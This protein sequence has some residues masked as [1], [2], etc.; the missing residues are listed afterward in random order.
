MDAKTA[1]LDQL[2][3]ICKQA[4]VA[5]GFDEKF[6]AVRPSDR[7]DLADFQCNGL[8]GV[9]K[10]NKMNPKVAGEQVMGLIDTQD[11]FAVTLVNPGF[12]NFRVTEKALI[13]QA[14]HLSSDPR[15]LASEAEAAKTYLLDY[16]GPNLAKEMHV[17]HL[18]SSIV[19]QALKTLLDFAGHRTISD[20]HLGD[21]GL[22]IGQLISQIEDER[23]GLLAGEDD[24]DLTMADLQT[25]YP[26][27][28]ARS[29]EDEVFLDR[30]RK[31]TAALQAGDPAYMALW[32]R[33]FDAS[34]RS[35]Q[36]DFGRMGVGFDC[37]YGE[38]RYQA[39]LDGLVERLMGE[40]HAI[41]DEGAVIIPLGDEAL[42]PLMLRNSKGGYGYGA[43]DLATI[44]DRVTEDNPDYILYIVDARQKLHFR[45]VF[46][47]A[48]LCALTGHA[49]PEHIPFGTVNG[50]DGKPFKT[51]AGGVMRLHDLLETMHKAAAERLKAGGELEPE[52]REA[53]AEQI[54]IAA[55]K[56]GELSHD[57]ESNYVFDM[58]QFLQFEGKTGPYI[59]YSCVR[60]RSLLHNAA[61]DGT[62][63]GALLE[64]GKGG[65][66]LI[67]CLDEFARQMERAVDTR[68][69]SALAGHVYK[70]ANKTN[71]YYQ[72]NKVLAAGVPRETAQSHL[73]LLSLALSQLD[74]GLKLLGIEIPEKM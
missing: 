29:K 9:A 60:I 53:I 68:K 69:P 49:K 15:F 23:P 45:Q 20:V 35:L 2:E 17:G 42:P 50:T 38:S 43:T 67:L 37:W 7:P 39:A 16:G 1:L 5:A 61:A 4:F 28:S 48:D 11:R 52:E 26:K 14:E 63:P 46:R 62:M 59:Q 22:Q 58:D 18:R 30:A 57:R 54:A 19:G 6:G 56:F 10:A 21:W 36:R 8:L 33:I 41:V 51:R 12:L 64:L 65:R 32:K 55:I 24:A 3:Q 74:L 31:A 71:T 25:W 70:L 73:G 13:E 40:G 34:S 44:I 66:D 47:A 27:A 72:S